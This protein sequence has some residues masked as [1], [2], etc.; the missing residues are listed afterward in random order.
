MG[1]QEAFGINEQHKFRV[2]VGVQAVQIKL[3]VDIH[4]PITKERKVISPQN[5]NLTSWLK[6]KC[7]G[8]ISEII[9]QP[10]PLFSAFINA[11]QTTRTIFRGKLS[12]GE[13]AEKESENIHAKKSWAENIN[14]KFINAWESPA[15]V[16]LTTDTQ[17]VLHRCV[18]GRR[19]W[20]KTLPTT[21]KVIIKTSTS[22]K[23]NL[24]EFKEAAKQWQAAATS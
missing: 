1:W 20:K 6:F 13:R 14:R 9:A 22:C 19:R 11:E 7:A 4:F 10:V 2:C 18:L 3:C 17:F 21:E 24:S 23:H 15:T 12:P 16:S 8:K 5:L